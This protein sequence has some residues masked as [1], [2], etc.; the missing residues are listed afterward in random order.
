[1]FDCTVT[2]TTDRAQILLAAQS[3]DVNLSSVAEGDLKLFQEQ[4]LPNFL[5]SLSVEMSSDERPPESRMVAGIILKNSLDT[6]DSAK[7]ELLIQQ[8]VTLDPS[9]KVKD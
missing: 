5:L 7:K 8:R 4:N 2:T 1:M 3:M 9:V 6:T